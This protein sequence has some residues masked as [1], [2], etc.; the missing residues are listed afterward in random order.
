MEWRVFIGVL[1][2]LWCLAAIRTVSLWSIP[3]ALVAAFAFGAAA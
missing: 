2:T 1:A 3:A